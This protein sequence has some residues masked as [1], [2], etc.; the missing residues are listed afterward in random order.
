MENA[1]YIEVDAGV[2]YWDDATINGETDVD[3]KIPL[4][5]GDGWCPIIELE[6][7]LILNWPQDIEA[8]VHYKVCDAG[9]YWLLDENKN[10]IATWNGHYVPNDILCR[11]GN[12][13]GDY[14]ILDIDKNGKISNWKTP[15]IDPEKW[16][17]NN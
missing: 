4:R 5:N 17:E 15:Y 14:I 13:Y 1:K 7:G 6:T 12:G 11:K 8:K 3:G 9:L 2:R 10:R 16:T